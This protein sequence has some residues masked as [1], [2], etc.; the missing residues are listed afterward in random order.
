MPR[1]KYHDDA[2]E[3]N[4]TNAFT[5]LMS[6]AFMILSF[7]L[8]LSSLQIWQGNKDNLELQQKTENMSQL[9]EEL[10]RVTNENQ[11]LAS[12]NEDL[13]TENQNLYNASPIIIDEQSGNFQF[14]SGSAELTSELRSYITNIVTPQINQIINTKDIDFIQVIGH[15]DGQVLGARA[16]G[17]LD[18]NLERVA[19]NEMSVQK[20]VPAS[21]ADLAL[22]RALAVVQE[23]QRQGEFKNVQFRAYTG[24]QLYLPS[25]SFAPVNRS[26]D[27][28][29][30]RMEIRFIPPGRSN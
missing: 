26:Q 9:L 23:L 15:T 7:F 13:K 24:A 10:D 12:I 21:N 3:L 20:L 11:Q 19:Q 2:D 22:M 1:R 28:T 6:N 25:G 18:Q 14:P 29:R 27:D 8:I 16:T 17:N 5:D 30:R 4:I